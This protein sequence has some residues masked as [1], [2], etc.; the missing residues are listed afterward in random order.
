VVNELKVTKGT[1]SVRMRH[2]KQRGY[3]LEQRESQ[4]EIALN[5]TRR[6]TG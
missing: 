3:V 1:V 6:K 2:L 5:S 4:G